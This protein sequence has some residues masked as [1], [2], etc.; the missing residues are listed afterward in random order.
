LKTLEELN[1][2]MLKKDEIKGVSIEKDQ[3]VS[4]DDICIKFGPA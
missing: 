1:E 2:F 4:F 3:E